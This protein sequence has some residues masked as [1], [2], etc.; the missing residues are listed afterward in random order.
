ML[1][2]SFLIDS[3]LNV[4]KPGIYFRHRVDA[5]RAIFLRK[6]I[7]V[8]ELANCDVALEVEMLLFSIVNG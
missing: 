8:G 1:N 2:E 6:C 4:R 5:Q 7:V 3:Y